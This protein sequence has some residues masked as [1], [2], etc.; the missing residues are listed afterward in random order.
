VKLTF[1]ADG[2]RSSKTLHYGIKKTAF[3]TSWVLLSHNYY[4]LLVRTTALF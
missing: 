4:D 1:D 3:R 2:I